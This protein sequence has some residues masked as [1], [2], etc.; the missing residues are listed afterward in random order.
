M[1]RTVRKYR[2][3]TKHTSIAIGKRVRTALKRA[4]ISRKEAA[5]K[6]QI[7][8]WTVSNIIT[9]GPKR[10]MKFSRAM[11]IARITGVTA[12][13]ILTGKEPRKTPIDSGRGRPRKNPPKQ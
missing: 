3:C 4:K 8:E 7:S 1:K 2:R 10:K 9:G 6:L 11:E 13:W 5:E 12:D